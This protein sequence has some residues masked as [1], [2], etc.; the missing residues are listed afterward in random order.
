MGGD[1]G[2]GAVVAVVVVVSRGVDTVVGR[3]ACVVVVVGRPTTVVVVV[4][5]PGTVVVGWG[6]KADPG[7]DVA[8]VPATSS[9]LAGATAPAS[10]RLARDRGSPPTRS[11]V[12]WS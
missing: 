9:T 1:D 4:G 12:S 6:I 10:H 8:I 2:G 7:D 5:R 11:F 3:P